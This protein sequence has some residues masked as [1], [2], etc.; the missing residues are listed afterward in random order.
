MTEEFKKRLKEVKVRIVKDMPDYGKDPYFKMLTAKA[1]AFLRKHP[2]PD[3][4]RNQK[5]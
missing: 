5:K 4:L 3:E 2:F 1:K